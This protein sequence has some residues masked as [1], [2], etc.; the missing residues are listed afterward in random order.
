MT[1]AGLAVYALRASLGYAMA[2]IA[3][4]AVT[5]ALVAGATLLSGAETRT[6]REFLD[7]W[8][9]LAFIGLIVTA[10]SALPGFLVALWVAA[11]HRWTRWSQ[12]AF[13]GAGDAVA[14]VVLTSLFFWDAIMTVW[15]LLACI[16]GGLAGG[17]AYWLAAGRFLSTRWPA[18]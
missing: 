12:F 11:R 16:A 3:A 17:A 13:A 15:I 9:T 1:P 14:A 10:V 4:T 7:D 8:A 5:V 2:V 18:A 6:V